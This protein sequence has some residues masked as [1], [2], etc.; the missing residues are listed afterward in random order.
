MAGATIEEHKLIWYLP[1][2]Y[3]RRAN[4]AHLE[5]NYRDAA[6]H[7]LN[8]LAAAGNLGDLRPLTALYLALGTALE[9][10]RGRL[11]D[12]RDALDR[13]ILIGR[14]RGRK[15]HLALAV[16][17]MGLHLKRF[18]NRPTARARGLGFLFEASR[19]LKEM[20]VETGYAVG[21]D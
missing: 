1:E 2:L 14:R 18:S 12:A 10:D 5:R 16:R 21:A 17:Q 20:D 9:Q 8:G 15:L 3:L 6:A 13:A 7:G 4:L 11:N 19:L